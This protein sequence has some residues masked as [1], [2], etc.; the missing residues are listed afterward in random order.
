MT[1][2]AIITFFREDLT[3]ARAIESCLSQSFTLKE[4]II[5]ANLATDRSIAI[6]EYYRDLYPDRID[7]LYESKQGANYARN[8]G[9]KAINA[10][11]VQ[12]LDADDEL[13]QHKVAHQVDLIEQN[14]EMPSLIIAA[15][16]VQIHDD[17][18]SVNSYIKV[19]EEDPQEA[20][21]KGLAGTTC[22]N[23]WRTNTLKAL[24]G[25]DEQ[26]S[27]IDD[28]LLVFKIISN[29]YVT[30]IDNN[31]LTIV[32]HWYNMES[33]SRTSDTDKI[34]QILKQIFYLFESIEIWMKENISDNQKYISL[35]ER[36]KYLT[37]RNYHYQSYPD[38]AFLKE[39][40]RLH[41]VKPK[42]M[43]SLKSYYYYIAGK[44]FNRNWKKYP[45]L[46]Y[47]GIKNINKVFK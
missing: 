22:S 36:Q 30:I 41:P 8:R 9:L 46:F 33:I 14:S 26:F 21:I 6:A 5:V 43:T 25:F 27:F 7:L 44:P 32:N 13:M 2:S 24:G 16:E 11:W 12:F 37:V 34:I 19:V 17:N 28:P 1:V 45:N 47:Q 10:D 4:I 18:G 20:L 35:I 15:A 40:V 29:G 39:F 38:I 31:P 23:L 3:L 42:I